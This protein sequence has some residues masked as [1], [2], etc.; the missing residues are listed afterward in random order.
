M[1]KTYSKIMEYHL[2]NSYEKLEYK[3]HEAYLW[4]ECKETMVTKIMQDIQQKQEKYKKFLKINKVKSKKLN[5][6]IRILI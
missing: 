6:K 2:P 1:D 5:S 3:M 4:M